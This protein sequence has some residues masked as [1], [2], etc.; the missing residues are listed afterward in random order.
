MNTFFGTFRKEITAFFP[1]GFVFAWQLLFTLIPLV[2]LAVLASKSLAQASEFINISMFYMIM[3]STFL[4]VLTTVICAFLA[5]PLAAFI[6]LQS[7]AI[8]NFCLFLLML[9]FS[10]NFLLHVLAWFFVLERDGF[11]NTLLKNIGVIAEPLHMLNS[12]VAV[13]IMMVYYYLPF[14]VLP[15][16]V[17]FERFDRRLIEASADLG[18][19]WWQTFYYVVI[20]YTWSGFLS[21]IFLVYVPAFGE[22]AIPELMGGDRFMYVGSAISYGMLSSQ[23]PV[24]GI[25]T[26]LIGSIFLL[27]S[28]ACIMAF[29]KKPWGT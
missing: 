14:M 1:L 15:L 28:L 21:G 24:F 12:Y 19:H 23:T 16:Y 22:F 29:L 18:A 17:V 10:T 2:L 26:T 7:V 8:K 9:P 20:P 27:I 4:A 6:A 13:L 25:I 3:R 11:L 5:Y